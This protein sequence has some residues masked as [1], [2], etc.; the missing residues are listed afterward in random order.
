MEQ[1]L[2]AH[3]EEINTNLIKILDQITQLR[4]QELVD[5]HGDL[6]KLKDLLRKQR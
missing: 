6:E 1:E 4:S 5:I 2:K 3:F